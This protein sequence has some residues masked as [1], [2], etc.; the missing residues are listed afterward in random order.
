MK[1]L[2]ISLLLAMACIT[3]SADNPIRIVSRSAG[4][5]SMMKETAIVCLVMDWSE[6]T[7]DNE[8][9][10]KEKFGEDLDY[11]IITDCYVNML[12]G[13]N[14][15][16]KGLKMQLEEEGAKYKMLIKVERVD[17]RVMPIAVGW[18]WHG[19]NAGAN[20]G[21]IWGDIVIANVETGDIMAEIRIDEAEEGYDTTR[22][23]CFGKTFYL[24]GKKVAK[25]K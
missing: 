12:A 13:F 16:S 25:L 9:S 23:G 21:Q 5:K 8:I 11:I 6:A 14:E 4:F 24:V 22:D 20:E 1:K 18:G 19:F 3:A 7:Y 15:H 2:F 17:W 10:V